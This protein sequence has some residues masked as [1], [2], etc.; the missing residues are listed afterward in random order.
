MRNNKNRRIV[1][2]TELFQR[3]DLLQDLSKQV[4]ELPQVN[5]C[6][7]IDSDQPQQV[8]SNQEIKL[9][10]SLITYLQMQ[11]LLQP[12]PELFSH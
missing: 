5:S 9:K 11:V 10:E 7:S 6:F 4:T 12:Q 1:Q 2:I 3:Q 8:F